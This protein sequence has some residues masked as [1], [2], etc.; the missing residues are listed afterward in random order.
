MPRRNQPQ[1]GPQRAKRRE[2]VGFASPLVVTCVTGKTGF[3]QSVAQA[4][5]EAYQSATSRTRVPTR[6]YPCQLCDAWHLT[7]EAPRS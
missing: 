5:L 6:I 1:R 7:S 2:P 3:P 4:K